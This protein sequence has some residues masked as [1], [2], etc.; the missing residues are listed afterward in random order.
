MATC[1]NYLHFTQVLINAAAV[2]GEFAGSI[3]EAKINYAV[4]V[5]LQ[6]E[7]KSWLNPCWQ[8]RRK[9]NPWI[10]PFI[11]RQLATIA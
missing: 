2:K 11:S 5:S 9:I 6:K 7:L 4:K 10:S 3:L 1:S 8:R